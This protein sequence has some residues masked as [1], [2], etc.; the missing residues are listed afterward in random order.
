[1][2][3]GEA[4]G[5]KVSKKTIKKERTM[6]KRILCKCMA[7]VLTGCMILQANVFAAE[8]DSDFLDAPQAV[9]DA[10]VIDEA[11]PDE[12][13]VDAAINVPEDEAEISE[14]VVDETEV[15]AEADDAETD[16]IIIE[17]AADEIV[18]DDF[19]DDEILEDAV[20]VSDASYESDVSVPAEYGAVV[21]QMEE[22]EL[23]GA[24]QKISLNTTYSF[25]VA[26]GTKDPNYQLYAFTPTETA[27]YRVDV[28]G[29]KGRTVSGAMYYPSSSSSDLYDVIDH[30]VYNN[31]D[32]KY[33]LQ[34]EKGRTYYFYVGPNTNRAESG[35]FKVRQVTKK[36]KTSNIRY[37][38]NKI[39]TVG[40]KGKGQWALKEN[41]TKNFDVWL[42][43]IDELKSILY[44]VKLTFTDGS[45]ITWTPA[46]GYEVGSTGL[47]MIPE[48]I[49]DGWKLD[50]R[51]YMHVYVGD[52]KTTSKIEI[53]YNDPLFKDVRDPSNPYYKAIY[54][55]SDKGIT[56]GYS[57]GTFGINKT[58]TR[59]EAVMFIWRMA[60]KPAPKSASKSPF[61]D[62]PTSHT[63]Y[64]AILWASQKGVTTGYSDKTFRPN[65]TCTR[66][67]IMTFVWR[68]KGKPKPKTV[69]KSPFKDVPK[70][71]TYYKAILWGS[72]KGITK[73]F[74]D[75]T[76]GINKDCSR[77]QIVTF[78]YRI[79]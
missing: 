59:G 20:A 45:S 64:K 16:E 22:E 66:G 33:T 60:G 41:G 69:S 52:Q 9:E 65:K 79:R 14:A 46:N 39:L 61:K 15:G 54:W 71:H 28:T 5:L 27:V 10:Y 77:G 57:D 63:F 73:G 51:A 37:Y 7:V 4:A 53:K 24:I 6:R 30:G 47:L 36:I 40:P 55:A 48:Q 1:M 44:D 42:F 72:Q 35:K 3:S 49:T 12:A 58:C 43:S 38:T 2:P 74:D 34:L 19:D 18:I 78:L 21:A 25:S 26:K 70:T 31:N 17:D 68:Y 8:P 23:V 76:F 62:V 29:T 75:G 50:Q 67:Q 11:A 56:K 32:L 13:E